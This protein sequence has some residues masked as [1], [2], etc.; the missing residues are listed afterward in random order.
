[1]DKNYKR[2]KYFFQESF[3]GKYLLSYFILACL[4]M[5]LFTLLFVF[6]SMDT[7]TITYDNNQLN[8]GKT[9]T[10]LFENL[11]NIHGILIVFLGLAILYFFTRFTHKT[12]GPLF[13]IGQ[14]LDMMSNGDFTQK[15]HLRKKDE[16]KELA[17]KVNRFNTLMSEKL[18]KIKSLANDIDKDSEILQRSEPDGIKDQTLIHL[19]E[20][21][22][23]LRHT[24]SFFTVSDDLL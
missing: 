5:V 21:N 16:C 18:S 2:K 11:L 4:A 13:K 1:M 3:Q 10:I 17:D 14:T 22:E 23:Q 20:S 9:P 7:L 12:V 24:L 6:F 19:R 15:I 8:F